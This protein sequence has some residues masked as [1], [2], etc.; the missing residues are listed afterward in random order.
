MRHQA[1]HGGLHL[2]Q[3]VAGQQHGAALVRDQPR[4][5]VVERSEIGGHLVDEVVLQRFQYA[6][7]RLGLAPLEPGSAALL[8]TL[9]ASASYIAVPAAMRLALPEARPSIYLSLSLGVTF[10]MNLTIGIP[11]YAAVARLVTGG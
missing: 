2:S 9:A 6:Q 1:V 10:P 7:P 4:Q 11:A 8:M 5:G 3:L